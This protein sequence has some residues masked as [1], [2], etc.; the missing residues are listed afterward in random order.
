VHEKPENQQV[1]VRVAQSVLHRSLADRQAAD[2]LG[3]RIAAALLDNWEAAL[4]EYGAG[5]VDALDVVERA[6]H[7]VV[8]AKRAR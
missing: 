6:A 8:N 7:A 4:T 5:A 2:R 1:V 3:R